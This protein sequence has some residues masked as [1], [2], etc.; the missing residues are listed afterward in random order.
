[1]LACPVLGYQGSSGGLLALSFD[2][3]AGNGVLLLVGVYYF[4]KLVDT[5]RASPEPGV[6]ILHSAPLKCVFQAGQ[7]DT[8]SILALV[9]QGQA[10]L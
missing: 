7:G 4:F 1:M 6:T 5:A 2:Q 3:D 9:R 8:P 10:D